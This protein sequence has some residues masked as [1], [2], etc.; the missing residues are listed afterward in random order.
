MAVPKHI[1][2][3]LALAIGLA[4]TCQ[5]GLQ[6][7][8]QSSTV[9]LRSARGAQG[10]MRPAV[11][12]AVDALPVIPGETAG[13]RAAKLLA[14]NRHRLG[15]ERD[16]AQFIQAEA[17]DAPGG[18]H[19]RFTQ[20]HQGIEVHRA[21]L[22]LSMDRRGSLT[23]VSDA[24]V[25]RIAVDRI[26]PE[27]TAADALSRASAA[28]GASPRPI[29]SPDRS[30]LVIARGEDMKDRLVYRVWMTREQPAGDW[31]VLVDAITGEIRGIEDRF[32]QH[33]DGTH[34]R[35]EGM[36]YLSDPLSAA[37]AT[38]GSE[39]FIDGGDADTDALR[40]SRA[41]VPLDSLVVENGMA[42]LRGPYC[43]VTDIEA[44]Y[45]P[46]T[47]GEP[48][49]YRFDYDR[50]RPGFEAVMVYYH[51][52][53]SLLRF[54]S[55]G[56]SLP[57]L[58]SLRLDPHGFQEKDNSHYSPSGNWISFGTGGVDDAEDADVIWHEYA[59]A[60]N[61]TIVQSWG[62]GECAALGE[63]YGDY[64]AASYARSLRQWNPDDPQRFWTFKWDGHNEFWSGRILN[65]DRS[66]PFDGLS[67]HMAGQIWASA[68]I[69]IHDLLGRDVTDMLVLKSIYYLSNGIT[70][71]DAAYALLQ[72]DRDLFDGAH[73]GV[74]R[75]VLGT[76]RGFLPPE[77][78]TT[79][80]VLAD[81]RPDTTGGTSAAAAGTG[82]PGLIGS[83]DIPS[84]YTLRVAD[85]GS[86]DPRLLLDA[87]VAV[88]LCGTNDEPLRDAGRRSELADFVRAG[89]K[90]LVEGSEV[91]KEMLAQ[92]GGSE[93][94]RDILAIGGLAGPFPCNR[95]TGTASRLFTAP[96]PLPPVLT[97]SQ[98]GDTCARYGVTPFSEVPG[99][100]SAA[101]WEGMP[102]AA[103]IVTRSAPE[104]GLRSVFF[105]FAIEAMEDSLSGAALLENAILGLLDS[106]S[107]A[108][109][110]TRSGER[111][112]AARLS[113]N[114]PNPFNPSTRIRFTLVDPHHTTVK[115]FDL[116]GREVATLVD[117]TR[118]AGTYEVEWNAKGLPSGVYLCQLAVGGA[119]QT[120][121]MILMK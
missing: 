23:M 40:A 47:Y 11:T 77:S 103:G 87:A 61:Y 119:V 71:R 75:R 55:L 80:L 56:F 83:M 19:V 73:L 1:G 110:E 46:E 34:V 51:A 107:P 116:L 37:R 32:V 38:Y 9:V 104:G 114:Y 100:A 98:R 36:T 2:A 21:E 52:T 88:V 84:G 4:L 45:D 25:P 17:S 13:A 66:Y 120:T 41:P 118:G 89:G 105:S 85:W 62:G 121:R 35:G 70:A 113:Q 54:E 39:G 49:P 69:D 81:G 68:L 22:V 115:V 26:D 67:P 95:L 44:P 76:E 15:I 79:I 7:G 57:R 33:H 5:A 53:Q 93:F 24:H 20:R 74:L 90:L 72:A 97:F 64:W 42:L 111:P 16:G 94:A 106:E 65:D 92:D 82:A 99:V 27:L 10:G 6:A 14:L 28:L 8:E 48:A 96:H 50:S 60:I 109:V 31:E 78:G 3:S 58:R 112:L 91:A 102:D 12:L 29:G 101:V 30:I 18:S 117:E 86:F 108:A 63:G 59:H 43:W